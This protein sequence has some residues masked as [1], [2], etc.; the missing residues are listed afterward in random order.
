[1][2]EREFIGKAKSTLDR[3][4]NNLDAA[5]L[6]RLNQARQ[7][8]L[9]QI[10]RPAKNRQ[11]WVTA[12]GLAAA[13]LLTTI[14]LFRAE[15]IAVST[16]IDEMEIIASNDGLDLYEQLDFYIWMAEEDP[17]AG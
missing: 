1:M 6:S 4:A 16:N 10:K 2:N 5:T 15:E 14:F 17:G 12:G 9:Q 7:A 3:Q 8:A 13:V 11:A